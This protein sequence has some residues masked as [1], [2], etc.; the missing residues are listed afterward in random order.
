LFVHLSGK[1]DRGL[2][3]FGFV[4]LSRHGNLR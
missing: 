3:T 4:F 1:N 2:L